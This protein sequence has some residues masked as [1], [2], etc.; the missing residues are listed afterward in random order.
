MKLSAHVSDLGLPI[1]PDVLVKAA[2]RTNDYLAKLPE[3]F[4]VAGSDFYS[5]LNQ[6]NSSGFIGEVLKHS[7]PPLDPRFAPNPHPDGRP[8]LLDLSTPDNKRHFQTACFDPVTKAPRRDQLAPFVRGGIEIKCTVGNVRNASRFAVGA[9]RVSSVTGLT[10]WAHHAHACALLGAYYDF[11]ADH[12]GSPQLR[13]IF[14]FRV[15]ES[16]WN[17]VSVGHPDKKKTSNTSLNASGK[18]KLY[19][20]LAAYDDAPKYVEMLGRIGVQVYRDRPR[21]FAAAP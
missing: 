13:A 1:S 18:R 21:V 7:I 17:P 3:R 5:T 14:F 12:N 10:Y 20:S 11:S 19:R 16:D 15:V 8:D 9:P 2:A 6:R 4:G